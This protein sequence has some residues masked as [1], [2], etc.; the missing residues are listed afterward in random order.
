MLIYDPLY[1]CEREI[2]AVLI[3]LASQENCDGEPYDQLMQAANYINQLENK[4][5]ELSG[6]EQC[7]PN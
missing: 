5:K 1:D 4:V 3:G 7:L 2:K 6:E